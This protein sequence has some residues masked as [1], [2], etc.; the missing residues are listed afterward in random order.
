M[1]KFLEVGLGIIAALGGF[2][3][4]G[5]LV[6]ASQ[7]GA[8]WGLHLL[9]ALALGTLMIIL[10]AEMSGRVAT[11]AKLPAFTIIRNRY[12]KSLDLITLGGS[13]I[14]NVMTCAA[15]IGGVALV[16]QLLSGLPY[17][18]LIIAAF[19]A[20]ILI[21]WLLPFG[22]LE[23]TFGYLGLGLLVFAVVALKINPDWGQVGHG[24]IPQAV[25]SGHDLVN[26]AYFAVGVIAATL[27]PYEV[28]FYSSGAIEEKW[29]PGDLIINKINAIVGFAL[30]ALLVATIMIVAAHFFEARQ[31]SPEFINTPALAALVPFGQAGLLLV[32]LGMLFA[33]GGAVVETTFA[34]AYNISQ[35]FNWRWGKH[36]NPLSVPRF[37][38][39]W[40][41]ILAIAFAIIIAGF[42]PITVTEYAVIFSVVVMPLTYLPILLAANDKRIM[43][44][45]KN[46]TWNTVLG[47]VFFAIIVVVS[48]A[49]VPLMIFTQRG[50]I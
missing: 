7:A 30:G 48:L 15:E 12:P 41:I 24:F 43:G 33:I 13:T 34:G 50:Q 10:Y 20:L 25:G 18:A 26:Y 45:Y 22:I 8:K 38:W 2:V 3:D 4:I 32:L 40:L 14:V 39:T 35:Y 46:K 1:K 31:I 42:D 5:D 23:K 49:A 11:V 47:W 36:L 19:L 6:F 29:K 21:I 27:M 37:T 16:L 28:Y 44:K 17:R 9:W